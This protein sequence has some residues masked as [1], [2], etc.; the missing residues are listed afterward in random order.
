MAAR[1]SSL[2]PVYQYEMAR[3]Y[4]RSNLTATAQP[5][6]GER[7]VAM[8]A[9]TEA[10]TAPELVEAIRPLLDSH[11]KAL[12]LCARGVTADNSRACAAGFGRAWESAPPRRR[13]WRGRAVRCG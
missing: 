7:F 6:Q 1:A 5:R 9:E 11:H 3:K 2:R 8:R 13:E 4:R 10:L 12:W